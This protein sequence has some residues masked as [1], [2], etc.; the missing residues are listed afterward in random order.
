[1]ATNEKKDIKGKTM[2]EGD[3]VQFQ[4]DNIS[5]LGVVYF[6]EEEDGLSED[7]F[8]IRDTSFASMGKIYPYYENGIYRIDGHV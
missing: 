1:M 5:G 3:I 2:Q 7:S 4:A 8:R 6:T